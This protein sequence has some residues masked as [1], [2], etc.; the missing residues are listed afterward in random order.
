MLF[1]QAMLLAGYVYA[2]VST[3]LLGTRIQAIVH[4]ALVVSA[5]AFLPIAFPTD[6][7]VLSGEQ[8]VSWLLTRLLV[9]IG[10]PFFVVSGSAP[11]LQTWYASARPGRDPYPLYAASNLGSMLALLSYPT[12]IEP[13]LPL[14]RQK[15]VW[16]AGYGLLAGLLAGCA[17]L[18]RGGIGG[19]RIGTEA[20]EPL[21]PARKAR[22]VLLAFVPSSLTLGATAEV[23]EDFAPIPL[24]WVV[25]LSL[26]LLSFILTFS[27]K[28]PFSR[29]QLSFAL[30]F[31]A[32]TA[33]ATTCLGP[34]TPFWIPF[35]L[36]ALFFAAMVCHGELARDRPSPA[37]L[38][39]FYLWI[40]IGGALGGFF[41]AVVA[42]TIFDRI[43]EY[44]L[45]IVIAC[46]LRPPN[47]RS[48]FWPSPRDSASRVEADVKP[49]TVSS[50]NRSR[51]LDY[52]VPAA[53]GLG[54]YFAS[55]R[56]R[57][58]G[59]DVAQAKLSSA[60]LSVAVLAFSARPKRFALGLGAVLL[61][62]GLSLDEHGRVLWRSRTFFGV[63]RVTETVEPGGA[64]TR[65]L[66]HGTTFHGQQSLD[67][68]L[69]REPSMYYHR[70]GPF[71]Q[72]FREF[73]L[74][75]APRSVAVVGLGTGALACYA[76]PDQTWTYYELDPT[77]VAAARNPKWF[78]YL[79]D[80]RAKRL[81]IVVGDARL[82]LRNA[83]D[84][85]IGLLVL[86]A[87]NSDAI[88]THLLTR[89]ALALYRR[90]LAPHGLIAVHV[91]SR[92]L[93]L[94][95]VLAAS[96]KPE[97]WICRFQVDH[98]ADQPIGRNR[99]TWVLLARPETEIGELAYPPRWRSVPVRADVPA[100]TD[101]RS[102]LLSVLRTF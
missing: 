36:L 87:F 34:I 74:G 3:R 77:V 26:Y 91:S 92:F 1:F 55:A 11:L 25:P 66:V 48:R 51:A 96:A 9:V 29:A 68:K 88:P 18:G 54:A 44:P 46:L 35:H 22:W 80:C 45:M 14:S 38:T 69:A 50:W 56:P 70:D 47:L 39:E 78:T 58:A 7:P 23:A 86:D 5:A 71:G 102:D 12:L 32:A 90:K 73:V 15:V 63:L 2:H 98:R 61:V 59:I 62:S 94:P 100:W 42:P 4:S 83:A 21:A 60:F 37:R 41:N 52:L 49:G 17:L 27:R 67:P 33:M 43:V 53:I 99:S 57:S 97:G 85:S 16:S 6:A 10:P 19:R 8:P 24:W 101:D 13:T 93:D 79:R 65:Q 64:R 28:P 95:P 40:S 75:Q 82:R 89:E 84:A 20:R 72:I 30:A 76:T 31:F 81:T